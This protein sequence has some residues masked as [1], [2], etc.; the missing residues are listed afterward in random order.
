MPFAKE[1]IPE[2][3]PTGL[4]T[5]AISPSSTALSSITIERRSLPVHC[6]KKRGVVG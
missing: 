5:Q 1:Q 3:W 6:W 4:I 2:I